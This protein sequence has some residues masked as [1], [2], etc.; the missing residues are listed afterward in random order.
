MQWTKI[1][2]QEKKDERLF[3]A[4]N[5]IDMSPNQ[6]AYFVAER[7]RIHAEKAAEAEAAELEG[8][9]EE[10]DCDEEVEDEADP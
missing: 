7:R 2:N 1:R 6:K 8:S 9:K 10:A 4:M 5:T 3:M